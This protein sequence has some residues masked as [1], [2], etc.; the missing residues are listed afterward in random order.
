[1]ARRST[2]ISFSQPR[3]FLRKIDLKFY[4]TLLAFLRTRVRVTNDVMFTGKVKAVKKKKT[5]LQR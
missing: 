3:T 2:K 1:M 4:V 5:R